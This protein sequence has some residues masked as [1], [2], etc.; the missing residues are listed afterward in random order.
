MRVSASRRLRQRQ[1]EAG[2]AVASAG[3]GTNKSSATRL[4]VKKKP[5]ANVSMDRQKNQVASAAKKSIAT[6][7]SKASSAS[8][9]QAAVAKQPAASA[10][11]KTS[12]KAI[13]KKTKSPKAPAKPS[14]A[15]LV[16]AIKTREGKG[17]Q[18]AAENGGVFTNEAHFESPAGT[19]PEKSTATMALSRSSAAANSGRVSSAHSPA[20]ASKTGDA[21]RGQRNAFPE[22]RSGGF[23][24][25][26]WRLWG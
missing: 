2:S 8:S 17:S 20:S 16:K 7:T 25:W 26:L 21:R 15:S 9:K 1:A 24:S 6:A 11:K 3:P 22:K 5:A 14:K 4:V 19:S 10:S 13:S 18:G 12:K 23:F